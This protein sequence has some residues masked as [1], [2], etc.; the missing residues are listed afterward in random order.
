MR[1]KNW[2]PTYIIGYI[3]VWFTKQGYYSRVTRQGLSNI[4]KNTPVI[5]AVNHQNSLIDPIV[6]ATTN[7]YPV[8]FLT[9]SDVFKIPAVAKILYSMNM[10]PIY[11]ERDGAD[12]KEKNI[13]IFNRCSELLSKNNRIII[14]PEGSH[15]TQNRLR[16]LKKGIARIALQANNESEKDVWI[17]PVGLNYT[18]TRNKCADLL[19]K[20]GKA[21]NISEII[22]SKKDASNENDIF[23]PIISKISEGL[24]NEMLD[25]ENIEYYTLSEF[26]ISKVRRARTS[27]KE[28]F[29]FDKE[30]SEKLNE[31]IEGNKSEAN[32]MQ[33]DTIEIDEVCNKENLKPYLFNK[34]SYNLILPILGLIFGFPLFI[35]GVINNYVPSIIPQ[36][37]LL[38]NIKDR[39]YDSSVNMVLGGFLIFLFWCIQSFIVYLL[40]DNYMWVLYF[41][42]C[43]FSRWF[44]FE[45]HIFY[46]RFI[47]KSKYNKFVKTNRE[48]AETLM[49]KYS[50]LKQ[51]IF[52]L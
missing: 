1:I 26:L 49:S 4:P 10:L 40:T 48:L 9:K 31:Y 8:F 50:S 36:K 14:F 33:N 13:A 19:V 17:V 24:K 37:F 3:L 28:R 34:K 11:R 16:P 15:N 7:R 41:L 43:V 32:K 23:N 42:S 29:R 39:Q 20:Y 18:N 52:N 22:Q 51:F 35:Y 44:S 45:Y 47:G 25:Y 6:I 46:L 21:I 12:F 27:V 2:T 5:F 38:K 30:K